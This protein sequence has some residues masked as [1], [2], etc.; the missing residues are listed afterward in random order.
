MPEKPGITFSVRFQLGGV[1][2]EQAK[3]S[4]LFFTPTADK[5]NRFSSKNSFIETNLFHGNVANAKNLTSTCQNI[6]VQQYQLN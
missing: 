5:K 4:E 1:G 3:S 6:S 2:K